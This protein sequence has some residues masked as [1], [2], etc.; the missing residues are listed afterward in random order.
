MTLKG[1]LIGIDKL[2]LNTI[3]ITDNILTRMWW[4][5]KKHKLI[6]Y[7]HT[8]QTFCAAEQAL[9][10]QILKITHKTTIKHIAVDL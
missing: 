2:L 5:I 1:L 8:L 10:D 4:T 3:P 6:P 7:C 9:Y